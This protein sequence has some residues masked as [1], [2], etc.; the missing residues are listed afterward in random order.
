MIDLSE[1]P[2]GNVA[3]SSG[4]LT[5]PFGFTGVYTDAES[6]LYYAI[7]RYYDPTTATW[8]TIDPAVSSTMQPYQYVHGDPL[9]RTD[10]L[11][12]WDFNPVDWGKAA[13]GGAG[14]VAGAVGGAAVHAAG[15]VGGAAKGAWEATGGNAVNWAQTRNCVRNPFGGDNNNGGCGTTL[16]TSQGGKLI[17]G[18]VLVVGG[19]VLTAGLSDALLATGAALDTTEIGG[20][21]EALDLGIHAPFILA[22]GLTLAG[23][24]LASIGWAFDGSGCY[25]R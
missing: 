23:L 11:G 6:G 12:L 5:T 18:T 19:T 2:Y 4:S 13:V 14:D 3:S 20:A 24:G 7:H 25:T 10:P 21:F 1:D 15:T 22:P 8:L 16:S 9:D 17:A